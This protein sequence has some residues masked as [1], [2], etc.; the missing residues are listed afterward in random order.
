M[1]PVRFTRT[2]DGLVGGL[3][4]GAAALVCP[5]GAALAFWLRL[6]GTA[7]AGALGTA[8][9]WSLPPVWRKK[10][11]FSGASFELVCFRVTTY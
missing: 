8:L 1:G 10:Q 4:S 2:L 11:R 5:R 6:R 3:E 7:A 9:C